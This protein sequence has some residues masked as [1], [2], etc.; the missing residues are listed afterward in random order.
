MNLKRLILYGVLIWIIIFFEV[1]IYMFGFNLDEPLINY[2][3]YIV[4][5]FIMGIVSYFYFKPNKIKKGFREGLITGVIF[6]VEETNSPF[7][8]ISKVLPL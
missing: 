4:L 8:N 5:I 2:V 1:S 6:G 3:H 7:I